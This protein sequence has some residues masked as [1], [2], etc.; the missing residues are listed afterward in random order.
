VHVIGDYNDDKWGSVVADGNDDPQ[1]G[2]LNTAIISFRFRDGFYQWKQL[3]G[4]KGKISGYSTAYYHVGRIV[5]VQKVLRDKIQELR[6]TMIDAET[7]E[8]VWSKLMGGATDTNPYDVVVNYQG[9]FLLVE[10]GPDLKPQGRNDCGKSW[11][12]SK[13]SERFLIL[14]WFPKAFAT[15]AHMPFDLC[16]PDHAGPDYLGILKIS[17]P[18][19]KEYQYMA[20]PK[21]INPYIRDNEY[22]H[23][24]MFLANSERD[25]GFFITETDAELPEFLTNVGC[26]SGCAQCAIMNTAY[27]AQC[28]KTDGS[29]YNGKCTVL[30]SAGC[31]GG[32]GT[33]VT[34]KQYLDPASGAYV[35]MKV[36]ERCHSSCKKCDNGSSADP[37]V[38][39]LSFQTCKDC[40]A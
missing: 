34:V 16:D 1:E 8:L 17:F 4:L 7:G 20:K 10:S 12:V 24:F 5:L 31:G 18:K 15:E 28:N 40:H 38:G 29:L 35:Q 2:G 23:R 32:P 36:C 37:L 26:E 13:N 27:C 22:G 25:S 21:K 19:T 11:E 39:F 3:V 9:I 33:E 6:M 30:N 14:M